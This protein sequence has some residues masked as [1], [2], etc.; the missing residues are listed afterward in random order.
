MA[1]GEKRRWPTQLLGVA[2]DCTKQVRRDWKTYCKAF[3]QGAF[4]LPTPK[5]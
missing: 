3:D 5:A 4:R 2:K 1:F